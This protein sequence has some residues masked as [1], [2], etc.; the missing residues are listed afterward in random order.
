MGA[1]EERAALGFPKGQNAPAL[2]LLQPAS[3]CQGRALPTAGRR[4][5]PALC[6]GGSCSGVGPIFQR[7][8]LAS[9]LHPLLLEVEGGPPGHLWSHCLSPNAPDLAKVC[10]Q[11]GAARA[12]PGL[13]PRKKCFLSRA[14]FGCWPFA[15][16]AATPN[17][18]LATSE[19][20]EGAGAVPT[21]ARRAQKGGGTDS[22]TFSFCSCSPQN[23][24]LLAARRAAQVSGGADRGGGRSL[25][26]A[27]LGLPPAA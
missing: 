12:L 13:S 22:A 8:P 21:P 26:P 3:A 16:R 5:C 20:Q 6:S 4:C 25:T 18:H 9:Y 19:S 17:L 27:A 10:W 23:S 24:A 14:P 7:P 1:A 2:V 15:W 11:T